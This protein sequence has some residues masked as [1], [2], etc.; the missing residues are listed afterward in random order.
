MDTFPTWHRPYLALYEQ[1][2]GS[3]FPSILK[4]YEGNPT[5]HARLLQKSQTWRL[6][7]FDWALNPQIPDKFASPTIEVLAPDGSVTSQT[8][9]LYAYT[10]HPIDPSFRGTPYAN[11]PTTYRSP[12]LRPGHNPV[13]QNDVAS[14]NLARSQS[15][16]K[17]WIVD[18]FPQTLFEPDPWS[19]FASHTW[20]Q[21]VNPSGTL[22]SLESIH[23]TVHGDIAGDMGD[24]AVAAFD[25][26][27]WLHHANVD[28]LLRLWEAVYPD[29][30]VSSGPDHDGIH[31][32]T[33]T[34][35]S[36][37]FYLLMMVNYR[38]ILPL[39]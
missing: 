24:P 6:P 26:I 17:L 3:H 35:H 11:W 5:V 2:L 33:F 31:P 10:F 12:L 27:F 15:D 22:T 39:S 18:L 8:N 34:L 30:Y 38:N 4:P 21:W 36:P 16:F 23:D 29:T 28:R 13:S 19:E 32:L 37:V 7:Y 1:C 14:A 9:P 25:P 20:W